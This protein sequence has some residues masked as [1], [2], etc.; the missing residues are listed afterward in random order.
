MENAPVPPPQRTTDYPRTESCPRCGHSLEN[1]WCPFCSGRRQRVWG[2]MLLLFG[3][4]LGCG[5]C[6][7]TAEQ[8]FLIFLWIPVSCV[9]PVI[10]IM[11]IASTK[12]RRRP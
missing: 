9:T 4:L 1:G 2:W 11:M 7:T 8:S 5:A 3:P 6:L 10:G 12:S